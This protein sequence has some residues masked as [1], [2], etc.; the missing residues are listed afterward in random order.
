MSILCHNFKF[1]NK[2]DL[3]LDYNN[4]SFKYGDGFFESIRICNG[5]CI[6]LQYHESRILKSIEILSIKIDFKISD[7][8]TSVREIIKSNK[9]YNGYIKIMFYR[10]EGGKYFPLDNYCDFIIEPIHLAKEYEINKPITLCVYRDNF[11]NTGT[12]SRI[13]STNCLVSILASINA[14]NNGYDNSI[15][16]NYN[17]RIVEVSNSNIFMLNNDVLAT[18]P[19]TEGCLDGTM[20][21]WV[22]DN[23]EAIVKTIEYQ[24]IMSA[25]EVF[26]TNSI[27]GI[28]PIKR[29]ENKQFVK[30]NKSKELQMKLI[31]LS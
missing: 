20:R 24:E 4:R 19:I 23:S 9:L 29:I 25:T 11:K 7:L 15:L 21:S 1:I 16:I 2:N 8:I 12:I 10:R 28:V 5:T 31:N 22:L 13:K 30:F 6:N 14:N 17:E 3:L 27:Y 26:I 18:P